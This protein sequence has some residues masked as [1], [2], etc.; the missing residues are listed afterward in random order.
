MLA[1]LEKLLLEQLMNGLV[2]AGLPCL[3]LACALWWMH[4]ESEKRQATT[5]KYLDAL[6]EERSERIGALETHAI[7]CDKERQASQKLY[8]ELLLHL[9]NKTVDV[10]HH[11]PT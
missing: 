1:M 11:S 3:L 5:Q 8:T 7:E 4:K 2:S 9:A 10:G 6:N